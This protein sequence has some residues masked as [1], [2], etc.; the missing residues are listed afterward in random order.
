MSL[1][2]D[3]NSKE[4]VPSFSKAYT[5]IAEFLTFFKCLALIAALIRIDA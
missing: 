3:L 2:T 4:N 1:P 5:T